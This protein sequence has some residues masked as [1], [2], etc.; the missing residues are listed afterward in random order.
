[1]TLKLTCTSKCIRCRKEYKLRYCNNRLCLTCKM[2]NKK[3]INDKRVK[4]NSIMRK[5][6]IVNCKFCKK[7]TSGYNGNKYC[8][9][10]CRTQF[11][12]LPKTILLLK[13][14]IIK[15]NKKLEMYESVLWE[16]K[17]AEGKVG[18]LV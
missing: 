1:M 6:V 16:G 13:Q 5:S 4:L 2:L 3:E 14:N 18:K 7:V 9:S 8:S 17:I 11:N 10:S 15:L 12:K